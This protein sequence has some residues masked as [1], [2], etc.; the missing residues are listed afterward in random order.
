MSNTEEVCLR[1]RICKSTFEILFLGLLQNAYIRKRKR[2]GVKKDKYYAHIVIINSI[3]IY[4]LKSKGSA[5][6]L[7]YMQG[8]TNPL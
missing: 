6:F 5:T 4:V 7:K 3:S 2:Y 8:F 1:I